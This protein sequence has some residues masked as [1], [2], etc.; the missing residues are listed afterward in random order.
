MRKIIIIGGKGNGTLVLS[1]IEEINEK[2]KEWD[3]LGFLNDNETDP[4]SDY[5]ILGKIDRV[6]VHKFLEDEDV[7]FYYALFSIK[8][9]HKFLPKLHSLE[10]PLHR[11]ATIIHPS[12]II[13][14]DVKIGYGTC[15]LQNVCISRFSTIGNFVQILPQA[16]LGTGATLDNFSYLAPKAYVGAYSYLKEGAYMGPA[17]SLI[18]FKTMRKWSVAGMG[19]VV[20]EDVPQ[21]S[22]VVGNPA[23]EIGTT[24]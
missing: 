7:Y 22:K 13:S 16:F 17:S 4:I 8:L 10:I 12:T 2:K 5:P 23:R 19:A 6:T 21:Y 1:A 3:V 11:L 18:E 14:K 15:I 9:N 20:V 24:K